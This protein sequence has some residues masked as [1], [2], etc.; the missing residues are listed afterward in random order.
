MEL[1]IRIV[2]PLRSDSSAASIDEPII[3]R[4]E[5]CAT[6]SIACR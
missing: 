3:S 6:R 1:G 2:A 4:N 5:V